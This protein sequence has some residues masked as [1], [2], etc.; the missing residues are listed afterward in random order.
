M[1]DRDVLRRRAEERIGALLRGKYTLERLLGM[2]GMS[3]VYRAV[4]RNGHRVAVKML[5]D[6]VAASANARQRFLQEGYAANNVDHPGVV[7]VLDDDV[8]EDGTAFVVMELLE[9]E[10]LGQ[11][12]ARQGGVLS[13]KAVL[14]AA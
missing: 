10:T 3:A 8:T 5:H 4:H 2:G 14:S 13:D 7:R 12:A 9:G 6:H 1:A 11:Q